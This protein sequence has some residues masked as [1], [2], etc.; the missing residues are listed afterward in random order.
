MRHSA[1][2]ARGIG[3]AV[4]CPHGAGRGTAK[5]LGSIAMGNIGA[6]ELLL[7]AIVLAVP[8]LALYWLIRIA[9]RHGT[10]DARRD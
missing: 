1:A 8:A 6:A 7:I 3:F 4:R 2:I 9:V 10:R 5:P